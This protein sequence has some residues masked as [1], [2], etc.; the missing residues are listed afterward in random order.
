MAGSVCPVEVLKKVKE[1]L[2]MKEVL[3]KI[4]N[5]MNLFHK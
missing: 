3:I 2:N 1:E 4:Y 5:I